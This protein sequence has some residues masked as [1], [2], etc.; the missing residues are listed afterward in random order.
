MT[1]ET[2]DHRRQ[3]LL[4]VLLPVAV[5]LCLGLAAAVLVSNPPQ[6]DIKPPPDARL[7]VEVMPLAARD[8]EIM[9]GSYG[10]VAPR[11]RSMLTSEVSGQIRSIAP[12]FRDGGA[13]AEGDVLM[14]IDKRVYEAN[15][16]IA[17]AAYMEANQRLAEERARAVQAEIDW[18]NLGEPA[19]A[20][21]LVLRRPQLLAAEA[22]LGS[23][24]ASRAK[25]ELDLERTEIRAPFDGRVLSKRVD[26][27]Q[28]VAPNQQL[29]EVYATDYV[30]IR[31]PL[32]NRDLEFIDLPGITGE[33][34]PPEAQL[35]AR[36]A[37]TLGGE[38]EWQGRIVRT[39]AAIDENARQL[40]V[41]AQVD[42]PFSQAG[43]RPPLRIGQYVAAH[44]QGRRLREAIMVPTSA[45]YQQTYAYVVDGDV[46]D[47]RLVD[48]GWQDDSRA[49][50]R[51]GL[52]AGDLLV[53][54]PLGQIASGTPVRIVNGNE[55]RARP[56]LPD[57]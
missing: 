14:R 21:D 15:V 12:G 41:I 5:L 16:R 3:A 30:E 18:Q 48:I 44:I 32:K 34:I 50:I 17:E 19:P 24:E 33:S 55:A 8:F 1:S 2:Q 40:H 49:F 27:G 45:I 36:I 56:G 31:L 43:A 53:V 42:S 47:R 28:V 46:L 9:L 23:A 22:R 25:A 39:E 52:A 7:M 11:T 35:R 57:A 4:K 10:T 54:T 29:A 38:F 37:S 51:S 20:P 6:A 13:F 26:V